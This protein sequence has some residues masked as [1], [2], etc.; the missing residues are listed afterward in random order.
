[1]TDPS[2]REKVTPSPLKPEDCTIFIL[3]GHTTFLQEILKDHKREYRK[4]DPDVCMR[5][6][7]GTIGCQN[8]RI[9]YRI[10]DPEKI[11]GAP[12]TWLPL[13]KPLAFPMANDVLYAALRDAVYYSSWCTN[14]ECECKEAC[15]EITVKFICQPDA[16]EYFQTYGTGVKV[17]PLDTKAD[18]L[19][20]ETKVDTDTGR[21]KPGWYPASPWYVGNFKLSCKELLKRTPWQWHQRVW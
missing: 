14:I 15:K 20:G 7:I 21:I 1:M 2:G 18:T 9:H 16:A 10:P 4:L 19:C 5:S 12:L 3:L 8:A 11:I 13:W 6:K 17:P